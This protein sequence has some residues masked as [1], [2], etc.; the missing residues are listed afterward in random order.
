MSTLSPSTSSSFTSTEV[1]DT[2]IANLDYDGS[3]AQITEWA[4]NHESRYIG[5]CNVHS[6]IS[7]RWT[8]KLRE[9]LTHSDFNTADGMPIVWMQKLLGYKD[10]SRVYGPTL[11]LHTLAAAERQGLKVAFYGGHEDRL[12]ILLE[13]LKEKFP[14]LKIVE[15]ISPP[16][17]AI[18]AEEDE[19]YTRRLVESEAQILWVGIGCPKQE[20]WMRQHRGRIPAV[21]LGVGA[22][23]DFHAGAVAQAPSY[24]Q[25]I[26]MEWAYRLYRE[27]KRLFKRYLTTN[28][29]FIYKATLQL[30]RHYCSFSAKRQNT[31]H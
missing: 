22:A 20:D 24:L 23:F 1:V 19:E 18:T 25:K 11:M 21:M 31:A 26:G 10:A 13:K 4:R 2:P 15:A 16:F 3:V 6:V 28:P 27:P 7:S 17:R 8:P 9:A 14:E 29:I 30:I 5:V 12:P